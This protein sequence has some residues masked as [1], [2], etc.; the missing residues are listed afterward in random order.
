[1]EPDA[2]DDLCVLIDE[3]EEFALRLYLRWGDVWDAQWMKAGPPSPYERRLLAL[4]HRADRRT[5]RRQAE[6]EAEA[7]AA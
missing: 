4:T 3:A 1:M 7:E 5:Q 6:L 2:L